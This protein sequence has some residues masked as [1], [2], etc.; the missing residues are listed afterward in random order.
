MAEDKDLTEDAV[1]ALL[2]SEKEGLKENR[3][4]LILEPEEGDE[5]AFSMLCVDTIKVS[6]TSRI[7][8]CQ[9]LA[10]GLTTL[11]NNHCED[12]FELGQN[13]IIDESRG[14]NIIPISSH[15]NYSPQSNGQLSLSFSIADDDG[16]KNA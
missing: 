2:E 6:E 11:L 3:I 10:R 1:L 4:Y 14:D 15:R 8:T 12:V 7:H 9:I 13:S 16:D 5:D